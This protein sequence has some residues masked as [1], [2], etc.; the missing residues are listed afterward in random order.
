MHTSELLRKKVLD[1]NGNGVGRVDD[2]NIN[3]PQWTIDHIILRRNLIKE[4]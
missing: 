1:K 4:K 2:I 3:L